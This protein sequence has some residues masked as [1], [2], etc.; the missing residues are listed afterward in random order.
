MWMNLVSNKPC[1]AQ[2]IIPVFSGYPLLNTPTGI[3]ITS[4]QNFKNTSLI[5]LLNFK[6]TI[7]PLST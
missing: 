5:L 2:F 4:V 1:F 7:V 3:G 6:K